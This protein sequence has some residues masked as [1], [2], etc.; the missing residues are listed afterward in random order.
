MRSRS[1]NGVVPAARTPSTSTFVSAMRGGS[2][3]L[4]QRRRIED[5]EAARPAERD[6]SVAQ[7]KVRAERELLA[8]QAVLAMVGLDGAR[9]GVEAHEPRVAAQPEAAA[10]I[11]HD[12]VQRVARQ[13]VGARQHLKLDRVGRRGG[14]DDAREPAAVGGRPRRA[15]PA[16]TAS[17]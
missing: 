5:V 10:R 3:I 7:P 8:L 4:R 14:I 15:R 1:Q 13:A 9:L 11:G 2:R 16:S 17:A 12:A 6:A